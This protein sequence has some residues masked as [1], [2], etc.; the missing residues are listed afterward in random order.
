MLINL[1]SN[2]TKFTPDEGNIRIEGW[3]ES[4]MESI[5]IKGTVGVGEGKVKVESSGDC[6]LKVPRKLELISLDF[7]NGAASISNI[8]SSLAISGVRGTANVASS[9]V[10]EEVIWTV[11]MVSGDINMSIP[12]DA[13]CSISAHSLSGGEI[14]CSAPLKDEERSRTQFK[15]VLNDG[16][17]KITLS[18]VK[19]NI[20][21]ELVK[22]RVVKDEDEDAEE[23]KDSEEKED[24]HED[25]TE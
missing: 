4:H 15:G 9:E 13:S 24:T 14:S 20:S 11:S 8:A 1:L 2:A 6:T 21:L 10:P 3:N 7:V 25:Q 5:D 12:E 19:G 16:T 23:E 22:I 17:A 18:T